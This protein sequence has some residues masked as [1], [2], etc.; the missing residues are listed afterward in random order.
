MFKDA[1]GRMVV[2]RLKNIAHEIVLIL[3]YMR[4]FLPNN[5]DGIVAL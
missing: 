4:A 2:M 5:T 3:L 1:V